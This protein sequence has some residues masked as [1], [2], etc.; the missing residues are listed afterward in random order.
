MTSSK[1]CARG[2]QIQLFPERVLGTLVFGRTVLVRMSPRKPYP[3]DVSDDEWAFVAPYLTLMTHDA[4]Q[5]EYPLRT[6]SP[7]RY[8]PHDLPPW[9]T[10]YEQTQRWLAAGCFESIVHDLRHLLRMALNRT[11][12]PTAV[13]LDGRT[14]QSTIE[15]GNRI[16]CFKNV[17]QRNEVKAKLPLKSVSLS[18]R[19]GGFSGMKITEQKIASS[20]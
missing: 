16:F 20:A 17:V 19:S 4:P 12:E 6:G 8:V 7:W 1:H 9:Q 3:S 14:L 5:R 18:A 10:V 11:P 13:V 2:E 15:S